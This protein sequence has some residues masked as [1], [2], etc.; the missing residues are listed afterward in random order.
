MHVR[1]AL[2]IVT[3]GFGNSLSAGATE[4]AAQKPVSDHQA[5]SSASSG[6]TWLARRSYSV[7]GLIQKRQTFTLTFEPNG[8]RTSLRVLKEEADLSECPD[9]S[10]A[11]CSAA[12]VGK[13]F[14]WLVQS[15]ST[16]EGQV[17]KHGD[18]LNVH[19][20]N[21]A[22]TSKLDCRRKTLKVAPAEAKMLKPPGAECPEFVPVLQPA[23]KKN[24]SAWVCTWGEMSQM[25]RS[26]NSQSSDLEIAV[27]FVADGSQHLEH[28]VGGDSC[29]DNGDGYRLMSP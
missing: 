26:T 6:E 24:V 23:A 15:D 14:K 16:V 2:L 4:P 20:N 17:A 29:S 18:V 3:L 7:F 21:A 5:P 25:S 13:P 12:I 1:H 19:F 27:A 11:K 28:V 9:K 22:E 10:I 8:Q